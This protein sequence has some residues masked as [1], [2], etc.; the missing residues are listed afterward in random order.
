MKYGLEIYKSE[1]IKN[2]KLMGI[3]NEL[4][5]MREGAIEF[6]LESN[7][8]LSEVYPWAI[9][10]NSD[11]SNIAEIIFLVGLF[12]MIVLII[13]LLSKNKNYKILRW[14]N[15]NIKLLTCFVWGTNILS[16]IL[17]NYIAEPQAKYSSLNYDMC[18]IFDK[19]GMQ[20]M[21]SDFVSV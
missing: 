21:P 10:H 3:A 5:Q 8:K 20:Q 6:N 16:I 1:K 17:V 9:D 14:F 11:I 2:A 4:R 12:Q 13:Y 7:K 15:K 19:G 18:K